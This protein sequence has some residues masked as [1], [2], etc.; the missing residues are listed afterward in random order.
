MITLSIFE[1][2]PILFNVRPFA[3]NNSI[4]NRKTK[5]R[6]VF[7]EET[8]ITPSSNDLTLTGQFNV[9][10]SM[11]LKLAT[12]NCICGSNT[13]FSMENIVNFVKTG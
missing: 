10:N 11:S 9:A 6:I 4:K 12:A 2:L 8:S 1:Y 5:Q 13:I 3:N 7:W